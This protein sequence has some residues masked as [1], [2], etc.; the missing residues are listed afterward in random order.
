MFAII[1]LAVFVMLAHESKSMAE[2]SS[3][4]KEIRSSLE[5]TTKTYHTVCLDTESLISSDCCKNI[6]KNITTRCNHYK[7]LCPIMS[8]PPTKG[9]FSDLRVHFKCRISYSD[10]NQCV[11]VSYKISKTINFQV[12][13]KLY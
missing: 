3:R 7:K 2:D 10:R 5:K 13:T 12:A 4:C 11:F 1:L 9:M 8:K 6:E